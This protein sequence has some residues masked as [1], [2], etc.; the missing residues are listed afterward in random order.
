MEKYERL[1]NY[2][3]IFATERNSDQTDVQDVQGQTG[4]NDARTIL[5]PPTS[6]QRHRA[7]ADEY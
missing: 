3:V 5:E 7:T 2:F 6:Y 1:L 4:Q